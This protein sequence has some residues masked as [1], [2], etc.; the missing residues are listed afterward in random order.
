VGEG[1]SWKLFGSFQEGTNCSIKLFFCMQVWCL[2]GT[3]IMYIASVYFAGLFPMFEVKFRSF[4]GA[5]RFKLIEEEETYNR[6][7]ITLL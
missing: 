5:M 2:K 7:V 1:P 6:V 3:G 4:R